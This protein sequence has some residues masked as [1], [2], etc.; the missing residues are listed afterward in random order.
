MLIPQRLMINSL[1]GPPTPPLIYIYKVEAVQQ[2]AAR[3][4]TLDYNYTSS[5]RTML[6]DLNWRPFE[7]RPTVDL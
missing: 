7:Q 5:V 1:Y 2:R 6:K 3:W 4:A